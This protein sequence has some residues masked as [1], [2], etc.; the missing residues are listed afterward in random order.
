[1]NLE[2]IAHENGSRYDI[3]IKGKTYGVLRI[4]FNTP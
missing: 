4:E 3:K 1:M 2:C